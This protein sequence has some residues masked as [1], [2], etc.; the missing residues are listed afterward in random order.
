[1]DKINSEAENELQNVLAQEK[2]IADRFHQTEQHLAKL[3]ENMK[4]LQQEFD[5]AKQTLNNEESKLETARESLRERNR[6]LEKAEKDRTGGTF[7]SGAV[8]LFLFGAFGAV[9]G[10][11]AGY[12][13]GSHNVSN[14]EQALNE[15]SSRVAHIKGR[16][17]NKEDKLSNL[18]NE[19]A[20]GGQRKIQES[21][22]LELLRAKKAEIK[23]SRKRLANLSV[24]FKSCTFL[25]NMTTARA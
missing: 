16:I 18:I 19:T 5:E 12:A 14:A 17:D 13:A 24:P 3:R 6:Q 8:G 10:V 25:V 9:A 21:Q 20:E 1:M 23:E 4:V 11:G 22:E 7:A 2:S 15:A